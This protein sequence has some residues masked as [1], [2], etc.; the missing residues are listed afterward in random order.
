[1]EEK[2]YYPEMDRLRGIAILMVLLY[3]SILVYPIDLAA[4]YEW[5]DILHSFLWTVEMPLFF[6]VSGFC[7]TYKGDYIGYIKKK[8]VRILIPHLVFGVMDMLIRMTPTVLV[9]E[10]FDF[11]DAVIEFVLY[12]A[13][14]WFLLTLFWILMLA[15]LCYRLQHGR[16]TGRIAVLT[17]AVIVNLLQNLVTGVFCLR[18]VVQFLIYFLIGM[19]W[20]DRLSAAAEKDVAAKTEK[21][22]T[23]AGILKFAAA[24]VLGLIGF[25]LM[26]WYGWT[27]LE[28]EWEKVFH[29]GIMMVIRKKLDFHFLPG[30]TWIKIIYLSLCLITTLLLCYVVCCLAFCIRKGRF[31]N[32]LKLCSQYSLQMYLLDGYALTASRI[33]LVSILGLDSPW[34]II[35]V[36]FVLDMAAVLFVSRFILNR[37][38]ILRIAAGL[39]SR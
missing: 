32:F 17:A 31:D 7:F 12:G 2:Q 25:A 10:S 27:G 26:P 35:P 1:M 24:L 19:V 5:C 14:D 6:L 22:G 21:R 3:H 23:A 16:R 33:L 38:K 29:A 20:R 37:W 34:I 18:N 39:R 9:N 13:N 4:E 11:K 8:A 36:N 28:E 15:P 30:I